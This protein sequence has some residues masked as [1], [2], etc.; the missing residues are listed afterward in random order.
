VGTV[1]LELVGRKILEFFAYFGRAFL[2]LFGTL[3]GIATGRTEWKP[4][5]AQMARV[6]V[7]S[8]PVAA[9]S[10]LVSGAV[11]AYHGSVQASGFAIG[12]YAGYL[13]AEVMAREVSPA[14]VAFVVSARAGSAITAELGTMKVTEQIDALRTMAVS[15]VHY[16]VI[17]RFIACVLMV[18]ALSFLGNLIGVLGGYIMSFLTPSLNPVTYWTYIPGHLMPETV[19][20]GIIKA[21]VFGMII[22]VICCHEGL[23]CGMASEEVGLAT[24]RAVVRSV[25]LTYIAD[26]ALAPILFS[27]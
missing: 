6:G 4:T 1:L 22:A 7:D 9:G 19:L 13:V 20:A 26:I 8:L 14:I 25:V 12:K 24:T 15:P 2:L 3:H 18:P 17:P 11:L 23:S 5:V 16:L 27:V 10:L 21:V